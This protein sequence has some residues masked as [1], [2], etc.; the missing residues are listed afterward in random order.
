MFRREPDKHRTVRQVQMKP[1]IYSL[2]AAIA[3]INIFPD[4]SFAWLPTPHFKGYE[5]N[6]QSRNTSA[7]RGVSLIR[8]MIGFGGFYLLKIFET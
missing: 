6:D 2:P 5:C 8:E 4:E 3:R 1:G 7:R